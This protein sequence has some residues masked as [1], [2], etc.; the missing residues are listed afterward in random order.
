[1]NSKTLWEAHTHTRLRRRG[2]DTPR[3]IRQIDC[4]HRSPFFTNARQSAS[5]ERAIKLPFDRFPFENIFKTNT[6]DF[7]PKTKS[8]RVMPARQALRPWKL[9]AESPVFTFQDTALLDSSGV[10]SEFA[11]LCDGNRL[12]VTETSPLVPVKQSSACTH[13]FKILNP[14]LSAKV[15]L[16]NLKAFLGVVFRHEAVAPEDLST[17]SSCE[18]EVLVHILKTKQYS[19]WRALVRTARGKGDIHAN[20]RD[21][22]LWRDFAKQRRKEEN[23]KYAFKLVLKLLQARFYRSHSAALEGLKPKIKALAFYLYHFP[24]SSS[25]PL[26]PSSPPEQLF[27]ELRSG[28]SLKKHW[29]AVQQFVLPEMGAQ[30]NHSRV[31]S[32]SKD[33]LA[34]F[35]DSEPMASAFADTL[36]NVTLFLGYSVHIVWGTENALQLEMHRQL[37]TQ[38]RAVLRLVC[39][40]NAIEL[41]KLFSEWD[42]RLALEKSVRHPRTLAVVVK[43]AVG[44]KNFKFP[45]TFREVQTAFVES[46]LS[47]LEVAR[48]GSLR[49]SGKGELTRVD[50][51]RSWK[52]LR[53]F[54]QKAH[55]LI[56][57]FQRKIR[58]RQRL[59]AVFAGRGQRALGPGEDRTGDSRKECSECGPGCGLGPDHAGRAGPAC[60]A[61]RVGFLLCN[62]L[63]Q[64]L[65]LAQG[66][67]EEGRRAQ[68]RRKI[69]KFLYGIP[70]RDFAQK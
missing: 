33:F 54:A 45:W 31:R 47:F 55:T 62:E 3:E 1:M 30:S 21:L 34:H 10:L 41:D 40:T 29:R 32:I 17:L 38:G 67:C 19:D 20:L 60:E 69:S 64:P 39:A 46:L 23:L 25:L 26:D 48:A 12:R 8:P 57:G 18:R 11:P 36:L 50:V 61:A 49:R 5:T 27:A 28:R 56:R 65:S 53:D 6:L 44:R 70:L 63:G 59:P 52:G 51:R 14:V 15:A 43:H 37:G 58:P 24:G 22:W 68:F 4:Q 2:P 16:K 66:T 7:E 13:K 9:G 35:A 42:N